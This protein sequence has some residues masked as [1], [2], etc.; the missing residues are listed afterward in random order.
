MNKLI[1]MMV[2]LAV[3]LFT[4]NSFAWTPPPSPKPQSAILDEAHVLSADAHARLDAK[5]TQ[6][7]SSSANEIAVLI[8]PTLDGEAI[9]DVGIATAKAWG[10]GKKDLDNGVLV[11]LAMKEHKSR[12]ETGKGVEGDLPDLKCND[13]LQH[14]L[15]PH[16]RKGDVEGGLS[17]TVDA[18]SSSIASHKA[19]VAAGRTSS[20]QPICDVNPNGVGAGDSDNGLLLLVTF[21]LL[22]IGIWWVVSNIRRNKR[23]QEEELK[24]LDDEL[25]Q[26]A[27]K[28]ARRLANERVELVQNQKSDVERS[29]FTPTEPV[30]EYIAPAVAATTFLADEEETRRRH[31]EE[32]REHDRQQSEDRRRRQEEEDRRRRDDDDSSSSSSFDFGG[33]DSGGGFDGGGFGGGDFGGGGSDGSW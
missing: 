26:H 22:G 23:R 14:T 28:F 24:R 9:S 15:A 11:V 10:V 18:I 33:G 1:S 29:T 16:M 6:I 21:G 3:A 20:N 30:T 19:D 13:I 5:L 4:V 2:A 27:E 8:L 32:R 17:A 7:N 31:D 25:N 12:I